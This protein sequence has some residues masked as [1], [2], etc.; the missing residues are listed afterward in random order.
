MKEEVE[1]LKNIA[2]VAQPLTKVIVDYWI[3]PKIKDIGDKWMKRKKIQ[4]H[5]FRNT[6]ENYL[7]EKFKSLSIVNIIAFRNQ[8]RLL[9]DIYFPLKLI[10]Q[11]YSESNVLL[12]DGYPDDLLPMHQYV[13]IN[14]TAGMGKSTIVK[15]LFLE[16]IN[17]NKGVPI[18]IELRRLS[19]DY[20]IID[21]IFDELKLLNEDVDK[22]FILDILKRG[23]FIVFLDGYDEIATDVKN[24]V[25]KDLQNFIQKASKN[26]FLLTSRPE[27]S[28]SAFGQFQEFNIVPLKEDEAFSL[29][30]K[31]DIKGDLS[32]TL[33]QKISEENTKNSI[34]DF[35]INP[36]L[37][38][39]LFTAFEYKQKVPLKKHIFYRQVFDALYEIH[40]L[41]KGD[42]Y[43]REKH[44]KLGIDDFH[45]ILR[46]LA[47][48]CLKLDKI[49]F[50]KDEILE[51][52]KKARL[53]C[54]I[55]QFEDSLF[56]KDLLTT[57][58]L[59]THEGIY[60]KWTH[61]SIYEYFACKFLHLDTGKN[62]ASILEQMVM[63][64]K[65]L[66]FLNIIDI[67]Y[68]VDYKSFLNEIAYVTLSDF[69]SFCELNHSI[70]NIS[71]KDIIERQELMYCKK[72]Y[73]VKVQPYV[74]GNA[75]HEADELIRSIESSEFFGQAVTEYSENIEA[76][77]GCIVMDSHDVFLH[78]SIVYMILK[79]ETKLV[80]SMPF[81][82]A[83]DML[84][85]KI[86]KNKA[87][88]V[89]LDKASKLNSRANFKITNN[90]LR[91]FTHKGT[92]L[93]YEECKTFIKKV[94]E[95]HANQNK[96]NFISLENHRQ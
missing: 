9:N 2:S 96:N 84:E 75:F 4:D 56:L 42:F 24:S 37:V 40:D 59:F 10:K 3:S 48:V 61:K 11:N 64:P 79:K 51:V 93:N 16:T 27:P 6:F 66:K 63:H 47:F 22:K 88:L 60:Y 44:S 65:G 67:Y 68:Y 83:I 28:L 82:H 57:V 18:F 55:I 45:T 30:R 21:L 23:D 38:S 39:L 91:A 94:N 1:I 72:R 35:L 62:R 26:K 19:K 15:K 29:I 69:I 52:I 78:S 43:K 53:N 13:L 92:K 87:L 90:L 32:K 49:E 25:T 86:P 71:S 17:N 70:K 81:D 46:Y 36:L 95:M 34:K 85:Y 14:D 33:I 41:S 12:I 74:E 58:P 54:E 89:N 31:Y 5:F 20:K 8:Q 77:G 76:N 7:S 50:T 73:V 80:N